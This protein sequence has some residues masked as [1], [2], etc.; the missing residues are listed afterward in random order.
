MSKN[1]YALD[2]LESSVLSLT[3]TEF[4]LNSLESSIL[5]S[6]DIEFL[7][8]RK[9]FLYIS[10]RIAFRLKRLTHYFEALFDP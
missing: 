4:A 5:S 8:E 10:Q 9:D 1:T 3:D 7:C 2:S 6:T